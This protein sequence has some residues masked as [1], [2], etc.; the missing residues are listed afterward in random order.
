MSISFLA[1]VH[2]DHYVHSFDPFDF[3]ESLPPAAARVTTRCQAWL[4][5]GRRRG[6]C[7][8]CEELIRRVGATCHGGGTCAC[9]QLGMGGVNILG[10]K[11]QTHFY[12]PVQCTGSFLLLCSCERAPSRVSLVQAITTFAGPLSTSPGDLRLRDHD[13]RSRSQLARLR[14]RRAHGYRKH[15]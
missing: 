2:H 9:Y 1:Q 12:F 6:D 13:D 11:V 7:L 8:R 10:N 5:R 4:P 14:G 15:M 3:G